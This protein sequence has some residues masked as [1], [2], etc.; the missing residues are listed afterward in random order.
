LISKFMHQHACNVGQS[1]LLCDI[2][3]PSSLADSVAG[4]P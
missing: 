1:S 2:I 4:Y 3:F